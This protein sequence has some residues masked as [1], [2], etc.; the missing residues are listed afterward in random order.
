VRT[1]P[2]RFETERLRL[3]PPATED[4]AAIFATYAR[5]PEV[6]RYLTW[7]PHTSP[8]DTLEF[9]KYCADGWVKSGPFTWVITLRE[10]GRL[11]GAIELRPQGH[12][13]ELGYVLGR[14][15]WGRGLMTEAVRAV[16]DW[17]LAQADIY[18]VWAVCD[19]ANHA[20]ARVLEKA[21]MQREGL[22]RA[23]SLHPNAGTA[24]RDC[25]CY[26]RAKEAEGAR[27]A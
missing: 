27:R 6:T 20:S 9:L 12:R 21:G 2:E 16:T 3:H 19:V 25:W 7:R 11:A 14:A 18:R 23:W 17:A 5:D 24:P 13:V 22:L 4:A 8:D 26:A 15:Y 10:S 1:P